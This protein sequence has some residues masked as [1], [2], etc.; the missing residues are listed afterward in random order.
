[1]KIFVTGGSGFVG[2][3][4]VH[5]LVA[6]GHEVMALARS[7]S[8]AQRVRAAGAESVPGD[9]ADLR[10]DDS[11]A[12]VWLAMLRNVDAVVHVAAHMEFWGPDSLFE[13]ANHVPTV[14][15]HAASVAAGVRRFVLVSAAAVSTGS[16]RRPVVDESTPEGRQRQAHSSTSCTSATW[17]APCSSR[18]RGAATGASTT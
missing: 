4:L 5:R 10:R 6:E 13:R 2:S 7:G 17:S 8:S 9:L 14:A 3:A 1:M 16:Q 15:L 12:P 11:P 18:S